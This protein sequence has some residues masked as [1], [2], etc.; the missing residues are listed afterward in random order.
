MASMDPTLRLKRVKK[1]FES[2]L[3]VG[4]FIRD[5]M[6]DLTEEPYF[7]K[8]EEIPIIVRA[9]RNHPDI[10]KHFPELKIAC[11]ANSETEL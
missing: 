9:I 7:L 3:T 5:D 10:K 6:S 8:P 11:E 2:G 1:I 4:T